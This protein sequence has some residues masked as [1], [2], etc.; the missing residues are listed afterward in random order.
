MLNTFNTQRTT[1]ITPYGSLGIGHSF[2]SIGNIPLKLMVALSAY[3]V[4]FGNIK[5][6]EHPFANDGNMI[7]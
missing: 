4:N 7:L 3:H 2:S 5:G 1:H 6:I